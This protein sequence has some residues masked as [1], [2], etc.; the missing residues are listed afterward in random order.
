MQNIPLF[1]GSASKISPPALTVT[2]GY[3]PLQYLPAENLN[4]YLNTATQAAQELVVTISGLGLSPS[5]TPGQ[6]QLGLAQ[7]LQG[8]PP[9]GLPVQYVS[10]TS[11]SVGAGGCANTTGTNLMYLLSL[12]TKTTSSWVAGTGVGGKMSAAAIA[13]STWYYVYVI[14]NLT[15]GAVDCGFDVSATAPTLPTGF[16]VYRMIA[17]VKTDGS[18][19]FLQWIW[20]ADGTQE[21]V[22]PSA[23]VSDATLTTVRKSYNPGSIPV[24]TCKVNAYLNIQ[25]ASPGVLVAVYGNTS[26]T[27]NATGLA[28]ALGGTQVSTI[29]CPSLLAI[30]VSA[31]T[32]YAR[33]TAASTSI[34]FGARDFNVRP[35]N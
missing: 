13:T 30:T 28:N 12:L 17:A 26:I 7:F 27:D 2:S 14:K 18:S 1:G 35:F 25:S 32:I 11:F 4:Y 9:V 34:Q 21:W 8:L 24:V 3:F 5:S 23:D 33:A 15:T 29:N 19:H 20:Y 22:T 10:T 31:G 6:L 16:T